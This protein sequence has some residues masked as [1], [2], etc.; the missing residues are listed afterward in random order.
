MDESV[1]E[2]SEATQRAMTERA[3]AL[4]SS[5]ALPVKD[6]APHEYK[7]YDC[8]VCED[9]LPTLRMQ[10]GLTLCTSCQNEKEI[11]QKRMR[12]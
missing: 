10:K 2:T 1:I 12:A 9:D 8:E 5:K 4:V 11:Y 7:R 3:L 6:L